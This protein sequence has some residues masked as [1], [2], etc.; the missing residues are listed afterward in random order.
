MEK[1]HDTFMF[2]CFHV[3]L[4]HESTKTY[5]FLCN[6]LLPP[7]HHNEGVYFLPTTGCYT[8]EDVCSLSAEPV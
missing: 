6:L 7:L 1:I 2:L 3:N 5:M 4:K 8:A